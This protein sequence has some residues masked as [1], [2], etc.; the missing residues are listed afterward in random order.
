MA[1]EKPKLIIDINKHGIRRE[2]YANWIPKKARKKLN[3]RDKDSILSKEQ[4]E[5]KRI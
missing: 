3:N 5:N 2:R 4:K 1:A